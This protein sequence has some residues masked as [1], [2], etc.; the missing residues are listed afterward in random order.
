MDY[1]TAQSAVKK[2][3][4]DSAIRKCGG[5]EEK[6]RILYTAYGSSG[7]VYFWTQFI[8][9]D[10]VCSLEVVDLLL[11]TRDGNLLSFSENNGGQALKER[12]HLQY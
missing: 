8:F 12:I 5:N 6:G 2:T 10:N 3:F 7:Q 9:L 4:M 11:G 1:C